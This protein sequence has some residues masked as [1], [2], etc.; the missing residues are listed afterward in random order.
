MTFWGTRTLTTWFSGL[1]STFSQSSCLTT[2]EEPAS[3]HAMEPWT[4]T[5]ALGREVTIWSDVGAMVLEPRASVNLKP[6]RYWADQ[7]NAS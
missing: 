5:V 1:T 7:P 2:K 6:T 4:S 3:S